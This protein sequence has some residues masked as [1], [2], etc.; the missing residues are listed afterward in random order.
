MFPGLPTA[1][2]RDHGSATPVAGGNGILRHALDSAN[3]THLILRKPALRKSEVNGHAS[4]AAHIVRIVLLCAKKQMIR[5]PA[6][7]VVALMQNTQAGRNWPFMQLP[8]GAMRSISAALLRAPG[9]DLLV[10]ILVRLDAIVLPAASW[11]DRG[12]ALQ[13]LQNIGHGRMVFNNAG[14]VK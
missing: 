4:L 8:G 11:A 6:L 2:Q 7:W 14:S 3:F 9:I 13:V 10:S 12:A 5:V 1:D